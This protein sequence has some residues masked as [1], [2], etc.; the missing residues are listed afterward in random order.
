MVMYLPAKRLTDR[1]TGSTIETARSETATAS[2]VFF[3]GV[4]LLADSMREG[5]FG[6]ALGLKM[7]RMRNTEPHE[8]A[9]TASAKPQGRSG[10]HAD[11]S[12]G[13]SWPIFPAILSVS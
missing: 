7:F 8:S 11:D 13:H 3:K 10:L 6:G 4:A 2:A 9:N 12:G 1:T 5:S